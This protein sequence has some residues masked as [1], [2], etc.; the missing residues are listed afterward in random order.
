MEVNEHNTL[1]TA[2]QKSLHTAEQK[3][4]AVK[5]RR[6][7]TTQADTSGKRSLNIRVDDDTYER[8]AIHALRRK[9]T[10]SAL[11]MEYAR[12]QLREFSIHRNATKGDA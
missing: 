12:T 8:L 11:V 4:K 6:R 10:I 2:E 7:A 3:S 9:T 5:V 1:H